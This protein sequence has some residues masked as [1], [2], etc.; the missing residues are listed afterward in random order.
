MAE[1]N[2]KETFQAAVIVALAKSNG[3]KWGVE[4]SLDV[5]KA[6]YC[7][8]TGS[9]LKDLEE[10]KELWDAIK[11]VVNPSQF[12]QKLENA[13]N[14]EIPGA[15]MLKRAGRGEKVKSALLSFGK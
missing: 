3:S 14:P 12:A 9:E 5:I 6:L 15:K 11:E 1:H 13:D 2:I 8:D 7:D 4:E 10:N